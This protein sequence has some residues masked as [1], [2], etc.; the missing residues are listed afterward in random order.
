MTTITN[1]KQFILYFLLIAAIIVIFNIAFRSLFFRVDLTKN[2]IYS[3]SNSSKQVIEKLDDRL[4][5][6]V[7]F[8]GD[9][10]GQY[11]NSRRF[12][13]DLLEEYQ[14]YS[15]GHF[16][17]EFINPDE[18]QEAQ[19]EARSYR[20]PPVQLQVVENDK[21]EVKKVFMGMVLIYND[22][23]EVL[24]V[25]RTTQG[26]E[27]DITS[28]IKK[29]T[30]TDLK[31]VGL[32]RANNENISTSELEKMLRKTYNLRYVSLDKEIPANVETLVMNGFLDSLDLDHLYQLD[33]FIMRGGKLFIAQG[34]VNAALRQGIGHEI[35]S[36]IF[37]FLSHYGFDVG[38]DMLIDKNCGQIQIQQQQG[39]FTFSSAVNYPPFIN[40]HRMNKEN[41]IVKDLEEVKVFFVN[42]L[43]PSD[44]SV[45]FVPL[46]MTSDKTGSISPGR[47][48]QP[49]M[50]GYGMAEG[51]N[52]SPHIEQ[53]QYQNPAMNSYPLDSKTVAAM[54]GG[55]FESY[56][57]AHPECSQREGFISQ[58]PNTQLL[59]VT[60][61][62]FFNDQRAAGIKENTDFILNG[63]D[64]LAGDRELL[65]I[66]SRDI[67]TRPLNEVSDATRK[68][69]KWMNTLLPSILI[70]LLGLYRWKR[71]RD[72]RKILE[73]AY[74]S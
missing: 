57:A 44:S 72:K 32:A 14:A 9:L 25:I 53:S 56:F 74:G 38:R 8:S 10:P 48:P 46:L 39:F 62:E 67:T 73:E 66:R 18:D 58:S 41:L 2:N 1:K 42:Q 12:L 51:Y 35:E 22:Q 54:I 23:T 50:R 29:L 55:R 27:Y 19:R 45:T 5:A 7:F 37:D 49:G 6:K 16:H 43:T 24:P 11:A 64:Y 33:Q 34:R 26:L 68:T 3:L 63:I 61:N 28:A 71:N 69:L 20:I 52:L 31:S 59:L 4:V 60:D 17:F 65:E 36:N 40:I 21:L 30:E 47:V 70:I 13:Q 15:K